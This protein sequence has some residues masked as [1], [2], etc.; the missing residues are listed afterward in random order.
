MKKTLLVGF[1]TL[2][3]LVGA[4]S[5]NNN[6]NCNTEIESYTMNNLIYEMDWLFSNLENF[7]ADSDMEFTW[8]IPNLKWKSRRADN[9]TDFTE[10]SDFFDWWDF[11][12]WDGWSDYSGLME[13]KKWEIFC[14]LYFEW[15]EDVF[16][17]DEFDEDSY[18]EYWT[19]LDIP[20]YIEVL[21]GEIQK[22]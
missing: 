13:Y 7:E 16:D 5:T 20:F 9:I 14:S 3:L 1:L 2:F 4:C 22:N 6:C 15:D 19:D 17:E 12:F 10:I 21:C 18:I 11:I 8:H